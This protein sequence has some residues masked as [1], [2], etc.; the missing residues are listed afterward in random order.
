[1]SDGNVLHMEIVRRLHHRHTYDE[2]AVVSSRFR[3]NLDTRIGLCDC[4]PLM[5]T[6]HELS[7]LICKLH[8]CANLVGLR[9][10][11]IHPG[12]MLFYDHH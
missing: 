6:I 2:T 7:A 8:E 4:A 1:M 11:P 10:E 5:R 9:D 12:E 3:V